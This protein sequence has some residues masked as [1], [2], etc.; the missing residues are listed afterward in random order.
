MALR[1]TVY[2]VAL[3]INDMD[4]HYYAAHSL[5]I[6]RHP[7]ETDER[8]MVR[9][10]AFAW[11]ATDTLAF[12]RGLSADDEAALWEH[13]LTGAIQMWI[14]VGLPDERAMRKASGR[15]DEVVL[16]AYGRAAD[17]WWNQHGSAFGR[18]PNLRVFRLAEDLTDTLAGLA[19]RNMDIQ[20]TVQEGELWLTIDGES[21]HARRE[22]LQEQG[23][24]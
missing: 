16:Y 3:Q 18:I 5:T 2:K 21:V 20:C 11:H 4:R 12:G 7:S 17:V 13:D 24:R 14:D 19:S 9:V 23:R 15:S 10:L 8:M 1:S 6:A 22:T